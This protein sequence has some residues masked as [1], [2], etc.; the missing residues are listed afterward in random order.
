MKSDDELPFMPFTPYFAER[1]TP[2]P[3]QPACAENHEDDFE[4]GA[5]FALHTPHFAL[6]D[7]EIEVLRARAAVMQAKLDGLEA[8]NAPWPERHR[9]AMELGEIRSRLS[10]A[11][12]DRDYQ[13]RRETATINDPVPTF[14][15][16]EAAPGDAT[17]RA[18]ALQGRNAQV[19]QGMFG[20]AVM[21]K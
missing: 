14:T 6:N 18:F 12:Y 4:G 15:R 9:L 21:V 7:D 16:N 11:E 8:N 5:A 19:M 3:S 17:V 20:P 13:R 1:P 10:A 2:A